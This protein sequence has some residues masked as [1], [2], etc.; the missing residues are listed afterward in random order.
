[1]GVPLHHSNLQ[2]EHIQ[3]VV[4]KVIKRIAGWKGRLLSYG[5]RLTLLNSCLASIP[6]YLMSIIK[7]PKWDIKL[8]N[9]QTSHFFWDNTEE[10]HKY[11]LAN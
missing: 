7:F 1:L 6:I 9:S 3:P 8:I 2:R 11:H 5:G 4:D 10:K